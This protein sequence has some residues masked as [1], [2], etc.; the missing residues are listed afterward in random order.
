M[1]TEIF[2]GKVQLTTV[3]NNAVILY[4]DNTLNGWRTRSKTNVALGRI[5]GDC[6]FVASRLNSLNDSDIIDMVVKNTK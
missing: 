5:S 2:L 4:G 1:K 3:Q 6:N